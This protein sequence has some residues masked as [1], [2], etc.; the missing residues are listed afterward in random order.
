MHW[1]YYKNKYCFCACVAVCVWV[2]ELLYVNLIKY[3]YLLDIK[4]NHQQHTYIVWPHIYKYY[5]YS[6]F[7]HAIL[8]HIRVHL[9]D[10]RQKRT[11]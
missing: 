11:Q 5:G 4:H 7:Y 1:V 6:N 8:L 3:I 9:R 2:C 10:K